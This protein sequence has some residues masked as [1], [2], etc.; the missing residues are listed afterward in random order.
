[1]NQPLSP[2]TLVGLPQSASASGGIG[3]GTIAPWTL[4]AIA[5]A[6][7]IIFVLRWVSS[8]RTR[9][10]ASSAILVSMC[11]GLKLTKADRRL[12]KQ[13]ADE[14]NGTSPVSLLLCPSVFERA[15]AKAASRIDQK[16]LHRLRQRLAA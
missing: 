6:A 8:R 12:L 9:S 3:L 1:M 15:A 16:A 7:L 4:A 11:N 5:L 13:L 14:S 2:P 10:A